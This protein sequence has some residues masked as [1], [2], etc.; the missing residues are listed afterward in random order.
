MPSN[1][2]I[3]LPP[4]E[5]YT[6]CFTL[7]DKSGK[8]LEHYVEEVDGWIEKQTVKNVRIFVRESGPNE[9]CVKGIGE[10]DATP[11]QIMTLLTNRESIG[12]WD[13]LCEGGDIIEELD[14]H[15]SL[16]H[17]RF[18]TT[19]CIL[20]Q[21]RDFVILR[22]LY[23]KDDGTQVLLG[24]SAPN[25]SY[26]LRDG[27]V[28]GEAKLGGFVAKPLENNR[29][30]LRYLSWSDLQSLEARLLNI[31]LLDLKQKFMD[32]IFLRQPL[33]IDKIRH[34]LS[35]KQLQGWIDKNKDNLKS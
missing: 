25:D 7:I 13:E 12:S 15:T 35:V 22:H 17:L 21:A 34:L 18:S 4:T 9:I 11:Q 3:I 26:P 23:V 24:I 16:V 33:N 30:E 28:R 5:Y 19:Y 1:P 2:D 32:R 29:S 20:K 14:L 6:D 31:P 10:V 8:D 27:Y